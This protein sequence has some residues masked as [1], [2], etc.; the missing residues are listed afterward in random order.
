M[1]QDQI[2]RFRNFSRS[3]AVEVGALEDSFLNRGRPLG[4]ARVLNAIGLGH[5]NVSD[6][7]TYLKL[8]TG[9]LSRLLR[10]LETEGLIET[11]PNPVDRRSR[12]TKLTPKGDQEF[13]VYE[14]LSNERAAN[15]LDRHKNARH[16]LDAMD[17]VTIALS[18]EDITFEEV[19]YTSE[20]VAKCLSAFAAELSKRLNSGFDLENSGDPELSQM[21]HPHGTFVVAKLG[22]MPLG[23]V[24]I[25]GNG[26]SVAEVKRMW[27]A[28]AARGLGLARRLMVTAED[29]A[30][31]LS[32]TTLR[33]DTNRILFEAVSLYQNM[34]WLEIDRF[35]DDPYP[36]IFFEKKL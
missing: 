19:Q 27:I 5:E 8:D 7:R 18:R 36:D 20:I 29:A 13:D 10:G 17:V 12:I 14:T 33:L 26:T 25:K 31:A 4:S 22:D 1:N 21:Q 11:K 28:P 23:C 2:N 6:L 16:L 3:V 34:G 30:R 15:I 35:N 32:I 9:L 24:G